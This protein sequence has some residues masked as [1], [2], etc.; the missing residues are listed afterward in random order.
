V[1]IVVTSAWNRV[2]PITKHET[3]LGPCPDGSP[4][5]AWSLLDRQPHLGQLGSERQ[6]QATGLPSSHGATTNWN[7]TSTC[8]WTVPPSIPSPNTA[9]DGTGEHTQTP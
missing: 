7:S 6:P 5:P 9:S 1:P 2:S 8:A 4:V 3:R